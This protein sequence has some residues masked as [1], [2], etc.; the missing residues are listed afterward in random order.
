M[1]NEREQA[2]ARA[3]QA[4]SDEM[5]AILME[6]LDAMD[7]PVDQ[8]IEVSNTLIACAWALVRVTH[9][10]NARKAFSGHLRRFADRLEALN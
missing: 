8:V 6:R 9:G 3:M 5:V 4:A 10:S 1:N 2:S 7:A